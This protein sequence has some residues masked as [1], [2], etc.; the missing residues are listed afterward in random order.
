ML[1][2]GNLVN[3]VRRQYSPRDRARG[4]R[5]GAQCCTRAAAANAPLAI[6]IECACGLPML[7]AFDGVLLDESLGELHICEGPYPVIVARGMGS[8]DA[9][10]LA[11]CR[12]SAA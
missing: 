12:R 1:T 11:G 5:C 10:V 8:P 2:R 9:L 6:P 4:L 3:H 7:R